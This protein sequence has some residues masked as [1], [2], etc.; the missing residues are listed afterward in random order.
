MTD[1]S[2]R[3]RTAVVTG[4]GGDM[5]GRIAVRLAS[6]GAN[7]V[8]NDR[9]AERAGRFE[10]EIK[11]L[12]VEVMTVAGSVLR[13][14]VVDELI[15]CA[16]RRWGRVDILV[17]NVGGIK[18]PI[19]TAVWEMPEEVWDATVAVNLRGTFLC[20]KR[21][22]PAM[23]ARRSGTVVNIASVAWA[24][25]PVHAAYAASKAGVVSFTRSV[26]TSV[27]PHGITVNA[28]APG[29]TST[30][31][32]D[33]MA[34]VADRSDLTLIP[35]RRINTPDDI[36]SAVEYLVSPGAANVSGQLITVAGGW[37]PAL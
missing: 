33:K 21:V 34:D 13:A 2:L 18:G 10:A 16:Q 12:G 30:S 9:A 23:M 7:V 22:L 24:G 5:G 28:I 4:S 27:A 3:G 1:F 11:D 32:M 35:L 25:D 31:V 36:A 14:N 26:A 19:E 15:E 8:L 6:L 29:L 20:T 17:N 37:N